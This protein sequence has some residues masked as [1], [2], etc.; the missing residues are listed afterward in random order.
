MSVELRANAINTFIT[1]CKADGIWDAIKACCIMAGWDS[2]NGA[3][4]PLKGAA[5]TN[6]N[7]VA[8]DYDRKTGLKGNAST[9]YLDSNRANNADP[10]NSK[11][12]ATYVNQAPTLDA[13]L[14]SSGGAAI[15]GNVTLSRTTGTWR[16]RLNVDVGVL[17]LDSTVI[18]TPAFVAIVRTSSNAQTIRVNSVT[19][20]NTV[21]SVAPNSLTVHVFAAADPLV[22]R[23]DARLA[24]YSIGEA[25]DLA[26]LDSRVTTLIS[27]METAI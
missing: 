18:T 5:P 25:L 11:H 21:A 8:G 27:E 6:F 13:F 12:L 26:Q 19:A 4:V 20:S 9:K 15:T 14:L 10:Q 16:G 7:F 22:S 23:A 2:L 24:F 3:L 17:T 1:G